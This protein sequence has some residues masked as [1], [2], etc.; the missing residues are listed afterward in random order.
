MSRHKLPPG[1]G[2][3]KGS[4]NKTT[5][6][7]KAALDAAFTGAGGVDTLTDWAKDNPTEF[8]R[9]WTKLLPKHLAVA[10]AHASPESVSFMIVAGQRIAFHGGPA[11]PPA[12]PTR[13]AWE[14]EEG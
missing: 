12:L 2:R 8:Y 10:S 11:A 14:G 5:V 13:D 4:Q 6:E 7:V 9:L 1:P 3:P